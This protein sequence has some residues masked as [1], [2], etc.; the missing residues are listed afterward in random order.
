VVW[1][2]D[3]LKAATMRAG[4]SS[5]RAKKRKERVYLASLYTFSLIAATLVV[6]LFAFLNTP[7]RYIAL[8]GVFYSA[9]IGVLY[10]YAGRRVLSHLRVADVS[11]A[12]NQNTHT[13]F[14]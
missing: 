11:Y 2:I 7:L 6:V 13:R 3:V 1:I 5:A 10:H 14:I 9:Y 4:A 12:P 8:V